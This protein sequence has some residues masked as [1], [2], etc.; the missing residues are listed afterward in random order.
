M[1]FD[2]RVAAA[3]KFINGFA[4][5]IGNSVRYFFSVHGEFFQIIA[6]VGRD[7]EHVRIV[8]NNVVLARNDAARRIDDGNAVADEPFS[9]EP[10]PIKGRGR[11]AEPAFLAADIVPQSVFRRS[12]SVGVCA[13]DGGIYEERFERSIAAVGIEQRVRQINFRRVAR[14]LRRVDVPALG[15]DRA[16]QFAEPVGVGRARVLAEHALAARV[17]VYFV[18]ELGI[19]RRT[20]AEF[21]TRVIIDFP[22]GI[23]VH[24]VVVDIECEVG[25][26]FAETGSHS[27]YDVGVP[28][29]R[30][31]RFYVFPDLF[32]ELAVDFHAV[33]EVLDGLAVIVIEGG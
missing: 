31:K 23:E 15:R 25:A 18:C 12:R 5:R 14:A 26:L 7:I 2:F 27:V 28:Y 17:E 13:D 19:E 1:R 6:R 22:L 33:A 4:F 8:L 32:V 24:R 20:D 11:I 29:R 16:V 21:Y 3:R 30:G 9:A 10:V